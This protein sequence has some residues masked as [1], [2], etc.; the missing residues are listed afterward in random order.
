MRE[1]P[2]QIAGGQVPSLA[3]LRPIAQGAKTS[4]DR[5]WTYRAFRRV[6][7]YVTWLLLHT[8]VT[9]NQVT[10]ASLIT[11]AAGTGRQ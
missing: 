6:S 3:E 10:V 7:I 1:R 8:G 2:S 5:R 11:A 9:P 4:G